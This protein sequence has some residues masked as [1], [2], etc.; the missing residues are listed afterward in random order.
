MML[1]HVEYIQSQVDAPPDAQPPQAVVPYADQ[2]RQG[3][4]RRGPAYVAAQPEPRPAQTPAAVD[5]PAWLTQTQ[6]LE[7]GAVWTPTNGAQERTSAMDRAEA[8]QVRL[9]PFLWA[10]AGVGVVV[11]GAVWLLGGAWPAGAMLG[12]LLFACL[13]AVT[14]IKLN[15]Q[16]Y[17]Y[18]REGTE[19]H[20]VSTAAAL[21]RQQM[22]HE[23][24]LRRMALEAYLES[25]ERHERGK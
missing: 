10:W 17:E 5:A 12:A 24:E 6:P 15:G 23:H 1:R 11:G 25:L 18:S 7:V 13:T 16:D 19:R 8:L 9:R 2:E 4:V 22:Q 3:I 21:S 20:R 14:Y